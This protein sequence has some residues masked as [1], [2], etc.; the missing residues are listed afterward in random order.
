MRPEPVRQ[1]WH[2]HLAKRRDLS[3]ELWD[4]LMLQAWLERWASA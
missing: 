4:V 1:A 3:Y 2:L